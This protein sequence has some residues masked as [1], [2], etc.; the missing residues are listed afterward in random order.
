[1][2]E[3]MRVLLAPVGSHG[4][5]HPFV[6][7]GREFLRLGHDVTVLANGHFRSLVE[8]SGLRLRELGTDAEFREAISHPDMWHPTRSLR[9]LCEY[10]GR[11]VEGTFREIERGSYDLVLGHCLAFGARVAEE[12]LG[13]RLVTILLSPGVL[14]SAYDTPR[15]P[16]GAIL[17]FLPRALKRAAFSIVDR[18]VVDPMLEEPINGFRRGLGL[19]PATRF[20]DR[21]WISDRRA[22]GLWPDWFG[23]L[24]P[25]GPPSLRLAGFPLWDERDLRG[26]PDEVERFLR[27]GEPPIVFAPGTAMTQGRSFFASSLDACRR[28]GAR[29]LLL[30]RHPEQVPSPLPSFA[31]RADYAPFSLLLPRV[32]AIVHHGGV[33]TTAQC[34]AA[35]VRQLVKPLAHDQFD[36]G[37]RVRRLGCGLVLPDRRYRPRAA[38][39]ALRR[40]LGSPGECAAIAAR[41]R[42]AEGVGGVVRSILEGA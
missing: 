37:E 31:L 2:P 18:K 25:D 21:W 36:N 40:L 4:D 3:R 11:L 19:P 28:L 17:R 30:T 29:A 15:L 26:V 42:A 6:G 24:Q 14:R 10:V 1:M 16:G 35:G 12:K 27:A 32:A 33:G 5:V 13:T 39:R 9:L 34:L 22:I 7:I 41:L 8:E 38:A 20:F 23:A